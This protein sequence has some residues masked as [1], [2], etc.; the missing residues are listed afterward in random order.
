[1]TM[2]SDRCPTYQFSDQRGAT[3]PACLGKNEAQY[4]PMIAQPQTPGS[5]ASQ[6]KPGEGAKI[7][8]HVLVFK[9]D[10]FF[11]IYHQDKNLSSTLPTCF[12]MPYSSSVDQ[13]CQMHPKRWSNMH[14]PFAPT[15]VPLTSARPAPCQMSLP[16]QRL[17][18]AAVLHTNVPH[19]F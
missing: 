16:G 9:P 8:S 3:L 11:M 4:D 5:S 6:Q 7:S 15:L 1:M 2:P 14:H 19:F 10:S 12:S 13:Y 18:S 17:N